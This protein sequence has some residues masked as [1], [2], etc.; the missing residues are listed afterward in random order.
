MATAWPV[1]GSLLELACTFISS[2][3][4]LSMGPSTIRDGH[5]SGSG[6]KSVDPDPDPENPNPTPRVYGLSELIGS[7]LPRLAGKVQHLQ[8]MKYIH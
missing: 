3:A 2:T 8:N 4:M 1:A 7:G 6:Y 5:G